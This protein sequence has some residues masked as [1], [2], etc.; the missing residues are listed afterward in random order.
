MATPGRARYGVG[1]FS[2]SIVLVS[3]LGLQLLLEPGLNEMWGNQFGWLLLA[4][5]TGLCWV[6]ALLRNPLLPLLTPLLYPF[7]SAKWWQ[8]LLGFMC[9]A[10]GEI[11]LLTAATLLIP[12]VV[13]TRIGDLCCQSAVSESVIN[14]SRWVPCPIRVI[15][16]VITEFAF[17][18]GLFFLFPVEMLLVDVCGSTWHHPS[19]SAIGGRYQQCGQIMKPRVVLLHGSG[20]NEC[21]FAAARHV[22]HLC[23]L[24]QVYSVNYLGSRWHTEAQGMGVPE[25]AAA[26]SEQILHGLGLAVGEQ[27]SV[28]VALVGHSLGGLVAAYIVEHNLCAPLSITRV[29]G[30]AAPY[31][32]SAL[33]GWARQRLPQAVVRRL[34]TEEAL[35]AWMTPESA[36]LEALRA[37]MLR[38]PAKYRFITGQLDVMVRPASALCLTW[39]ELPSTNRLL[40]PH[41]HHYNIAGS[42]WAWRQVAQWIQHG[43]VTDVAA[44]TGQPPPENEPSVPAFGKKLE[45]P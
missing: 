7:L 2:L 10:L 32:G 34:R 6:W 35:D 25:F 27:A 8:V 5:G 30:V 16:T 44:G 15:F 20:V 23:G 26:A 12:P 18:P 11:A 41:L 4:L 3:F 31:E 9:N 39:S 1:I 36:H 17:I 43:A 45:D 22:L 29:V 13:W 33:L 24:T 37:R 19:A 28:P 40:L 14:V 21:Q 42:S 38:S